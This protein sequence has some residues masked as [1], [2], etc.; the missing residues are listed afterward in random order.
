M[1]RINNGRIEL[2]SSESID[3][4]EWFWLNLK[5]KSQKSCRYHFFS[6]EEYRI[7]RNNICTSCIFKKVE[8]NNIFKLFGQLLNHFCEKYSYFS[9]FII[10]CIHRKDK[11]YPSS[12]IS[13]S[14]NKMSPE[15]VRLL[16]I[17]CRKS[18]RTRKRINLLKESIGFFISKSTI[19]T[20]LYTIKLSLCVKSETKIVMNILSC[21]DVFPPRE[22]Y[23]ISV[24]INLWRWNDRMPRSFK[25]K[26]F[27]IMKS[28]LNLLWFDTKL[29]FVSNRKPFCSTIHLKS[30]W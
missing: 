17:I 28:F 10:E 24:P 15:S 29:I 8:R 13:L 14:H 9:F 22:F 18:W 7:P 16:G 1:N 21:R 3:L 4:E 30:F 25:S 27:E 5:R 20:I 2:L 19:C 6:K 26:I 12:I 11:H 23:L